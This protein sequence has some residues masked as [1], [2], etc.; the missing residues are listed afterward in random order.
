[1]NPFDYTKTFSDFWMLGGKVFLQAQEEAGRALADGMK[2]MSSGEISAMPS[3]P[4]DT[5]E[6]A[7]A[8]QAMTALWTAASNLSASLAS[9]L[10]NPGD[11]GTAAETAFHKMVDPRSWLAGG[12][13]MDEVLGRMAQGPRFADLWDV[14]RRYAAVVKAWMELRRRSLEH[15]AVVLEAWLRRRQTLLGGGGRAIE[16]WW[17]DAGWQGGAGAVD[18]HGEPGTAG[19]PAFPPVPGQPDGADPCQHR[20]EGYPGATWW[21]I[22]GSGSA[23]RPV[24]SWT[25]CTATVTELRREMRTLRRQARIAAAQSPA[26]PPAQAASVRKGGKHR[27][28]G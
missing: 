21:S 12:G 4:P 10:P 27:K 26:P 6:L 7:R 20:A 17:P 5:T 2:A 16:R 15:Q 25:M 3:M 24:P 11:G 22:T 1:M 28:G 9:S 14:E 8:S 23:S 13:E 18:G 19:N